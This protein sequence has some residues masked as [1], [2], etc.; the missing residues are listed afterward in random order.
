MCEKK[1]QRVLNPSLPLPHPDSPI[2]PFPVRLFPMR[3]LTA[4]L[5][6]TLVLLLGSAGVSWGAEFLL[7]DGKKF[8]GCLSCSKY[9]SGSICNKYGSYGSKYNS[10][11]IWNKYGSY[12]S[13][14]SSQSP[15]NKYSS[16]GPKLVDRNGRYYGRFSINVYS[17]FSES[18]NLKEIY[19]NVDGDLDEVRNLFCK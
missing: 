12:G 16:S 2:P 19:E 5:C 7:F 9:G 1:L 11:S 3:I 8:L 6:L 15:W 13:K 4:T 10:D 18:R 17:G 14:Y